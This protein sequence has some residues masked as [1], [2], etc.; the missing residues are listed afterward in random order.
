MDLASE[1]VVNWIMLV[2][3]SLSCAYVPE[4]NMEQ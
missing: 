4:D 1:S 3:G 2:T